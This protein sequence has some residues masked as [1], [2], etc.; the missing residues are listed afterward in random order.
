MRGVAKWTTKTRVLTPICS[1]FLMKD[2]AGKPQKSPTPKSPANPIP[3]RLHPPQKAQQAPGYSASFAP[4]STSFSSVSSRIN[5]YATD[6]KDVEGGSPLSPAKSRLPAIFFPLRCPCGGAFLYTHK[7]IIMQRGYP[8][9]RRK[10]KW[11]HPLFTQG[12]FFNFSSFSRE[13]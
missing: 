12:E 1:L 13:G 2:T 7:C 5:I 9:R 8:H 3:A 10:G 6:F 11:R 4:S